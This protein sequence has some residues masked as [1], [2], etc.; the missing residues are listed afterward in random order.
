MEVIARA[1]SLVRAEAG[2][3]NAALA[4]AL[5]PALTMVTPFA[6]GGRSGR[7]DDGAPESF[8]AATG[9]RSMD[10]TGALDRRGFVSS[11][12]RYRYG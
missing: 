1:A 2:D 7:S 4:P 3:R 6:L 11:L 9:S 10:F 8:G 5:A 12:F